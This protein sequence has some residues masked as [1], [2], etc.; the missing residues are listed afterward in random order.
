VRI[1]EVWADKIF[2]K[3]ALIQSE[4][5]SVALPLELIKVLY[6]IGQKTK[7]HS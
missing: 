3:C 1:T 4:V 7:E 2:Q 6:V 5:T